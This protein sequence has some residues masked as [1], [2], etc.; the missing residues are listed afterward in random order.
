MCTSSTGKMYISYGLHWKSCLPVDERSGLSKG[1]QNGT[2][3]ESISFILTWNPL[4][5]VAKFENFKEKSNFSLI[6]IILP[7]RHFP[8]PT[9][10]KLLMS[11][12][13][14]R[15]EKKTHLH[16]FLNA[17]RT[18]WATNTFRTDT[19]YISLCNIICQEC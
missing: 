8:I 4:Q 2:E 19:R 17:L 10:I 6:L 13:K 5:S 12:Q 9:K 18:D 15:G 7:P 1:G 3:E 14:K 16:P 11:S